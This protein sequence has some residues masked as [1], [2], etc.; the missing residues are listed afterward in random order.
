MDCCGR[1]TRVMEEC[2][3]EGRGQRRESAWCDHHPRSEGDEVV[4]E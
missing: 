2:H 1:E 4:P 3:E